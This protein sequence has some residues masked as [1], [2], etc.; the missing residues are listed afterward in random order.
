MLLRV[1]FSLHK[2]LE[3]FVPDNWNRTLSTDLWTRTERFIFFYYSFFFFGVGG[4]GVLVLLKI[5]TIYLGFHL[6]FSKMF[7]MEDFSKFY[8]QQKPQIVNVHMLCCCVCVFLE[9]LMAYANQHFY[10]LDPNS[11]SLHV[12]Y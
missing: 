2:I 3:S 7:Q 8:G 12:S 10:S 5:G 4:W 1:V 9:L 11:I 6:Q